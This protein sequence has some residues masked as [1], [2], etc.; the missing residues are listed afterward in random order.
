MMHCRDMMDALQRVRAINRTLPDQFLVSGRFQSVV[1]C[2]D[3]HVAALLHLFSLMDWPVPKDRW[4]KAI[5]PGDSVKALVALSLGAERECVRAYDVVLAS[6]RDATV[7]AVVGNLRKSSLEWRL[8]V[9]ERLA[10]GLDPVIQTCSG[11]QAAPGH[12]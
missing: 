6:N 11:G 9:L 7:R 2:D 8:P 3:R 5:F 4:A 12:P 10:D 1:E